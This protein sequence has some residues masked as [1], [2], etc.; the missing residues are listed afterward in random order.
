MR[1][2]LVRIDAQSE[3]D[4]AGFRCSVF[5]DAD[6]ARNIPY[7][8][9]RDTWQ[10]T[11]EV[12]DDGKRRQMALFAEHALPGNDADAVGLRLN[13]LAVLRPRQWG[14]CWLAGVLW[15]QLK[16]DQFWGERADAFAQRD[17]LGGR[18]TDPGHLPPHR[19]GLGVAAAPA[20]V[21]E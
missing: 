21:Y 12:L 18:A 17:P 3:E 11:I 20:V 13:E 19:P 5:K 7:D 14:A 16:L 1:L 9:Q 8:T 6:R 10:R 2:S 4:T 15:S